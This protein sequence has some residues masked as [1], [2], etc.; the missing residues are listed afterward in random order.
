MGNDTID[1]GAANVASIQDVLNDDI[2][3]A[4]AET[5]RVRRENL[6]LQK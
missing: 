2:E 1:V 4:K 5:E 3:I 6:H